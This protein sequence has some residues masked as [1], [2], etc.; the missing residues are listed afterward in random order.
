MARGGGVGGRAGKAG[1]GTFAQSK[2]RLGLK[3]PRRP[4]K[5]LGMKPDATLKPDL[6]LEHVLAAAVAR[7]V[8]DGTVAAPTCRVMA[9]QAALE[10][11]RL[12]ISTSAQLLAELAAAADSESGESLRN[13]ERQVRALPGDLAKYALKPC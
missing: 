10:G 9:Y 13:A 3:R 4:S 11:F 2:M 7:R 12:G 5:R 8:T 1:T 6:A